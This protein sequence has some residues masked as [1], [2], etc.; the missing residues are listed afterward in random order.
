MITIASRC[1]LTPL[2]LP[3]KTWA[4]DSVVN[5][6]PE[7]RTVAALKAIERIGFLPFFES[8]TQNPGLGMT[9]SIVKDLVDPKDV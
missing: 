5:E 4:L 6:P 7:D 9:V 1:D 2:L 3:Q 8:I